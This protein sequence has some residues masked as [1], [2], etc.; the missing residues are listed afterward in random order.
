MPLRCF[1]HRLPEF[2]QG[3]RSGCKLLFN[4][5]KCWVARFPLQLAQ[6][7]E[8]HGL[9]HTRGT[10]EHNEWLAKQ[11]AQRPSA[12]SFISSSAGRYEAVKSGRARFNRVRHDT[13]CRAWVG[14]PE[15]LG[16]V[17]CQDSRNFAQVNSARALLE[18]FSLLPNIADARPQLE[19]ERLTLSPL[20][21]MSH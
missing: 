13:R 15:S 8:R 14:L 20:Q 1:W 17:P 12:S 19:S 2:H 10:E 11:A 7:T 4:Y 5:S 16:G 9:T 18:P 3:R 21:A 6:L